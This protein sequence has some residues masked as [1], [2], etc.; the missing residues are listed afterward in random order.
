[1]TKLSENNF[2][3]FI[4]YLGQNLVIK[5]EIVPFGASRVS[6]TNESLKL[7]LPAST[8]NIEAT[9]RDRIVS[10]LKSQA[11]K[12][13]C[14]EIETQRQLYGFSYK[15]ISLK[16]TRSRW[17]SCSQ[18][19]NLNFNWRLIMAPESVL[20]YVVIHETAHFEHMNHSSNFWNL[21]EQRCPTFQKEKS[22]LKNH[23]ASLINWDFTAQIQDN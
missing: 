2:D 16:D 9:A 12:T 3:L 17:G 23:G 22:W 8:E 1:L 18:R 21:V 5:L 14:S 13:L 11:R 4:P 19:G 10:W 6:L 20:R 15:S 7:C